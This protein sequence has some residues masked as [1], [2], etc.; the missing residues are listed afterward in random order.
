MQ[1]Y[2]SN[3]S[4]QQAQPSIPVNSMGSMDM[5]FNNDVSGTMGGGELTPGLLAA[6]GT[7]G[8]PGEPPLLE[9]LGINFSHIKS[10]TLVVLN[11]L[12]KDIPSDIMADSDLAGPILFVLLFGTLLLLAG[13]V[14]FGYI[15]G[16]GLF[17]TVSLHYLFKFMSNDTQIDLS[18]SASVI[19][20]CLLPLVLISV[21]GVVANLDNLV[22]YVLSAVAVLWCT[23][24]ASGF[25][26]SV[27]KLHNVRPLIAYPLCISSKP[28]Y[29]TT[30]IFY[31]NAAPHIGHLYSMMIADTRIR[32]EKLDP[33]KRT[34]FLT[35]TD[36]HGLKIQNT[37]EKL[38]V[39][40][41]ELVDK[42]SNNFK[43]LASKFNIKYDRFI[44]TTDTDHVELAQNFWNMMMEKGY[45]YKGT[46]SGWYCVS[47]ETFYPESSIEEIEKNGKKVK[48]SIESRNEVVYETETNY[49]FKLSSFQQHLIDYLKQ[50]PQFIKPNHR[51]KFILNELM[52]AKLPDLSVSRPSLRL[53]WGIDV[54]NDQSQKIYVWFDALLNYLTATGF[55]RGFAKDGSRYVTLENSP[56]PATHIIGKDI[57]RF[58]CIYWPIFLMAANIEPPKQVVVHSHWL[59]EGFKMSKSLGN[60]VEPIELSEYYGVDPVRF[61]LTENSNIDDDCKFSEALL[62]RSRDALVGKYCNL[63]SRIG[64][65][66]FDIAQSVRQAKNG[67]FKNIEDLISR[68]CLKKGN[69]GTI[70]KLSTELKESLDNVYREMDEKF[71]NFDYIRAIQLWWGVI[72]QANQMFQVAEP[73]LYV[74]AIKDSQINEETATQYQLLVNYFVYLCAEAM[75]ISSILIQPV[76]PVLS[77]Q[78]LTRLDVA[79]EKRSSDFTKV[80]AD[81]DYGKDSNSSSHK[82][83]LQKVKSR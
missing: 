82:P 4:Y 42:V 45:I 54:P 76:M 65:K 48:V 29:V 66:S 16:V 68:A 79:L 70:L 59:C 46:H 9:E 27:L 3:Y 52:S 44:R 64:G 30:P 51:Y 58:H 1:F 36:E 37:A 61:F 56:W 35:G 32:W 10:K 69:V 62:Q 47:D 19:G 28:F 24:S 77:N 73:W 13:K 5:G 18:R 43:L 23:Y 75:R 15:Y 81:L 6:F 40:P 34:Y 67:E 78:V 2:Q 22:G 21:V 57:I 8:Y 14:Q 33:A 11:P 12:M 31:V 63:L 53:K 55:P 17:G 72:N 83:P 80:G 50:N 49:F 25:F 38:G 71:T 20:Y 7:S 39:E 74:T 26:V 60:V 41:K